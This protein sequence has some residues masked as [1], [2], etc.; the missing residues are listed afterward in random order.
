MSWFRL[1]LAGLLALV[2]AGCGGM[3]VQ[4]FKGREPRLVI[5]DYFA[6]RTLAWGMFHDRFGNLRR[7]FEVTIDG[8][9]DEAAQT[10]TLVEDFV[11]ADGEEERRVW[12]IVKTGPNTYT[13]TAD[14]VVGTAEGEA[15]G[16]TLNWRYTFALPVG[17]SVWNVQFDDWLYLQPGGA[18][19]NRAVVSKF[20]LTLGEVSLAFV[21]PEKLTADAGAAP[22]QTA[23]AE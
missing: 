16:N 23:A 1:G 5:E 4:D 19:L 13:G 8:T 12:T 3:N 18:L 9:W 22:M 20:G 6:G 15:Q 11:Y 2:L 7:E 17:E 21:K 10:L 14:G